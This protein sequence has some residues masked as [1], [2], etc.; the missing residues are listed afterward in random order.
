LLAENLQFADISFKHLRANGGV[1]RKKWSKFCKNYQVLGAQLKNQY[2]IQ[3]LQDCANKIARTMRALNE[4]SVSLKQCLFF[5]S[6]PWKICKG[7]FRESIRPENW[8]V[9]VCNSKRNS[10]PN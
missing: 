2:K 3:Q 8:T 10:T 9:L 4:E 1:Y 5:I 6:G 7:K